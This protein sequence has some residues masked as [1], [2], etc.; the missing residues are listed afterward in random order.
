MQITFLQ[1]CPGRFNLVNSHPSSFTVNKFLKPK[2]ANHISARFKDFYT[3]ASPLTFINPKFYKKNMSGLCLHTTKRT[4]F[5]FYISIYGFTL[6]KEERRTTR[7][8]LWLNLAKPGRT[9]CLRK[10]ASFSLL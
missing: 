8:P 6:L 7:C 9:Y 10:S 2:G 1:N 4:N 5:G 3:V